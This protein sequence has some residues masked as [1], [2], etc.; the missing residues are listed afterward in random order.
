MQMSETWIKNYF[1]DHSEVFSERVMAAAC[2][3][4]FD[5]V[6]SCVDDLDLLDHEESRAKEFM[7]SARE[8][9]TDS[10][11]HS[12]YWMEF[13][14][15]IG[16]WFGEVE[17]KHGLKLAMALFELFP[18]PESRTS[19]LVNAADLVWTVFRDQYDSW[20]A[21]LEDLVGKTRSLLVQ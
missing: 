17:S 11:T 7:E 16:L 9:V 19:P 15:D 13:R 20:D 12:G 2:Q 1:A 10:R 18:N 3:V 21:V 5:A 8:I 4:A 14:N 6:E